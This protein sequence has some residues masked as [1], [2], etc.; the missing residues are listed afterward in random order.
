[1]NHRSASLSAAF[2]LLFSAMLVGA[3][4]LPPQPDLDLPVTLDGYQP[5]APGALIPPEQPDDPRDEPPPVFFGEEIESDSQSIV[6]VI[7]FSDSMNYAGRL[8]IAKREFARSVKGLPP[9]WRFNVLLYGCATRLW[10]PTLVVA[11]DGAKAEATQWVEWSETIGG[12]GT[13]PAV[14]Q[15]LMLDR[16]NLAVVL[17]TDGEPN[18]GVY[19]EPPIADKHRAMIRNANAQGAVI[20]VFGIGARGE[21]RAF[22]QGVATDAFGTYTDVADEKPTGR[23]KQ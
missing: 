17:L 14:A 16:S 13:G 12:T 4:D 15:G 21:F 18:C 8:K 19:P 11:T 9:A 23:G 10:K 2:L 3:P 6:Y 1:M 7:D 5:G 20:N 22:C